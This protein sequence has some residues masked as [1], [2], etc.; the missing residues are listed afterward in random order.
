MRHGFEAFR[1]LALTAAVPLASACSD[2]SAP[3]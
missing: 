2:G 1:Y 3:Q